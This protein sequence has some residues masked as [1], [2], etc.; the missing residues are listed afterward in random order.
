[1]QFL[2]LLLYALEP[3]LAVLGVLGVFGKEGKEAAELFL[4]G[5]AII[6]GVLIVGLLVYMAGSAVFG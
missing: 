3:W 5:V 2:L 1:M 4:T 6:A